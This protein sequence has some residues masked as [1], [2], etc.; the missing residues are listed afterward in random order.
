MTFI[1]SS[2]RTRSPGRGRKSRITLKSPRGSFVY[3]FF[4]FI[5]CF[6]LSPKPSAKNTDRL[7]TAGKPN[8][9]NSVLNPAKA[10]ISFFTC[11]V[12]QVFC[13]NAFWINEGE[14]G[15]KKGDTVLFLILSILLPVPLEFGFRHSIRLA[16]ISAESHTKIWLMGVD[17]AHSR[18]RNR[19]ALL[20][21]FKPVQD[22][23][24]LW[25]WASRCG[26][27][28]CRRGW[29]YHQEPLAIRVDVPRST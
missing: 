14:L 28:T 17:N 27:C 13:D 20:K 19:H 23:V 25:P 16:R 9:Q 24:D 29:L 26:R 1:P 7:A 18:S 15:G 10:V 22:D 4:S 21:L 8:G 5:D 2:R 12:R 6:P 3:F 11:T